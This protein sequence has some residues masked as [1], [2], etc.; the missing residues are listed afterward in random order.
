MTA[1]TAK[2]VARPSHLRPTHHRHVSAPMVSS[3][4]ANFVI[5]PPLEA[6]PHLQ[7]KAHRRATT[8][9]FKQPGRLDMN[10]P[11]DSTGPDTPSHRQRADSLRT[12]IS[13]RRTTH[14]SAQSPARPSSSAGR[15]ARGLFSWNAARSTQPRLEQNVALNANGDLDQDK[16]ANRSLRQDETG[17]EEETEVFLGLDDI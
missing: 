7:E 2:G 11:L 17:S 16:F 9:K 10:A 15:W 4:I 5:P 3:S 6:R 1:S 8:S 14:L 13:E 12:C